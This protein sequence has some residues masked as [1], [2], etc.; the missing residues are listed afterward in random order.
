MVFPYS[1]LIIT[2]QSVQAS[3]GAREANERLE[4]YLISMAQVS[5]RK[6]LHSKKR[7]GGLKR[8]FAGLIIA[9]VVATPT[10][11]QSY[12]GFGISPVLSGSMSPFAE[13]GDAFITVERPVSQLSVGNIVTLHIADSEAFYAHRIIEIREQSGGIK[14][15]V[16]KG[17]AN[18]TAEEDP[19]MASPESMVPVTLFSVKWI[20]YVLVY[21][22]SVQG[23]QAGLA[24]IVIAN[25]LMLL[26]TLFKKPTKEISSRGQDIYKGLY[27]ESYESA[28]KENKKREIYRD[29]YEEAHWELQTIRE[30]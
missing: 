20:G 1:A 23:R 29:L 5:T 7:G 6:S 11:L 22:T 26:L 28:V 14:R 30:K 2:P 8:V 3:N 4:P 12:F 10:V 24:L 25:V 15:I 19:F 21:L 17:D 13:A 16:T 9:L 27:E 18:P